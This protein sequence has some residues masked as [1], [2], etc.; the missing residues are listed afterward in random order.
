LRILGLDAGLLATGF[1]V[2]EARHNCFEALSWGVWRSKKIDGLDGKLKFFYEQMRSILER[3]DPDAVALEGIYQFRN[4]RSAFMLAHVRGALIACAAEF[5]VS[6]VE[7]APS[8]I[9]RNLTGSGRAHKEQVAYAVGALL[10]IDDAIPA[11]ASDALAVAIS[12]A[13][14][15]EAKAKVCGR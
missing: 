13:L 15:L 14:E 10:G 7:L 1:G 2:V 8:R 3:F 4:P 6:V 5:G 11:D 12:A 9:K